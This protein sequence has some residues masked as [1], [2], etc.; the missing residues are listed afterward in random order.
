M[1]DLL[2]SRVFG[3]AFL[4]QQVAAKAGAE[5][6]EKALVA[7]RAAGVLALTHCDAQLAQFLASLGMPKLQ[8][9]E[10]PM[11]TRQ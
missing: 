7:Q 1:P 9:T 3:A 6:L 11:S 2:P 8:P 4:W 5:T 10:L